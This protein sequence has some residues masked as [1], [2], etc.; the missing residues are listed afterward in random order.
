MWLA[1]KKTCL[2]GRRTGTGITALADTL[3]ALNIG[4]GSDASI[5]EVSEIY[6]ALKFGCYSS[7]IEMAEEIGPFPI[8]SAELEKDNP[9]LNRFKGEQLYFVNPESGDLF[10]VN[11]DD[12]YAEMQINGRR[13][14]ALLTSAPT[15]SV[16]I[17][18][19]AGQELETHVVEKFWRF[20]YGTSSGIEPLYKDAFTRRRKVNPNDKHVKID[21]KDQNG[22]CW[23]EYVVYHPTVKYWMAQTKCKDLSK[24]PWKGYCAEDI[25]WK[26]RVRL[27]A[28]AQQHLD[29]AI[30]STI[31]LPSDVLPE[32][33]AEIY[34]TAWASGCKGMTVYRDG[35]RTGVLV[36]N[37]EKA[38]KIIS[39][40]AA[41]R[42]KTMFCD[43]HHVRVQATDFL[44]LVGLLSGQP[45]EVLAAKSDKIRKTAKHGSLEKTRRGV[46]KLIAEN[47]EII[48][49]VTE[50]CQDDE[51]ALT[52]MV[53]TALRHG[54]KIDF[55]VEQLE[56]T[57][58]HLMSFSK[59]LARAL[60]KY[61]QDGSKVNGEECPECQSQL[62]RSEGCVKCPQCGYSKCS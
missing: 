31:N 9:F 50:L 16:S 14:I 19:W 61:I 3:A 13:N 4:Y 42:P 30:S 25:D 59:C 2:D 52:R 54:A 46:Y 27:Q 38:G 62:I 33:V 20:F 23:E 60:K 39:T 55:I 53:S 10:L 34:E 29:H 5:L 1:I 57:K 28:A 43:I 15:G 40:T 24:S 48:D 26:Q 49:S 21:F 45:Y 58:G 18:A 22:D 11:G 51:E 6:K 7:S 47:G 17:V 35:C 56:K 32:K 8:W 44:V 41:K 12:I 37:S 36:D